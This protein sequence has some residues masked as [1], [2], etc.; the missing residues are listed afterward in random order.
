MDSFLWWPQSPRMTLFP[1]GRSTFS[2]CGG[3]LMLVCGLWQP[4]PHLLLLLPY[5][6]HTRS[7]NLPTVFFLDQPI[8]MDQRHA[9]NT[10]AVPYDDTQLVQ[11]IEPSVTSKDIQ[12]FQHYYTAMINITVHTP[13]HPT[14][15]IPSDKNPNIVASSPSLSDKQQMAES[16]VE[17]SQQ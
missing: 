8:S 15:A 1:V 3:L 14:Q 11:Q 5:Y 10:A 13:Y 4:P 2:V 9:P 12:R 7:G 16:T 17:Q 6:E